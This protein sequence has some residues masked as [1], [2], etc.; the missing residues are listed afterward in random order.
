MSNVLR[1]RGLVMFE[2][3]CVRTSEK[4]KK[5]YFNHNNKIKLIV[6]LDKLLFGRS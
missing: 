5:Y 4:K 1:L 2:Y 6:I 3:E